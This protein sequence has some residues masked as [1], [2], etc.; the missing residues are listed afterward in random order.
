METARHRIS[1][2]F[3]GSS[4]RATEYVLT[5]ADVTRSDSRFTQNRLPTQGAVQEGVA[6]ETPILELL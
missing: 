2:L 4:E 6:E 1:H 3:S 5:N